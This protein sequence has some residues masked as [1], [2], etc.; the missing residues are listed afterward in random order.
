[1]N[2]SLTMSVKN[3]SAPFSANSIYLCRPCLGY[4]GHEEVFFSNKDSI[5]FTCLGSNKVKVIAFYREAQVKYDFISVSV[6]SI[7]VDS[8]CCRPAASCSSD[9][10]DFSGLQT[11]D[12]CIEI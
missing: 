2:D 8:P 3:G 9:S 11:S 1:M 10:T 7:R 12:V 5:I 6:R 4:H